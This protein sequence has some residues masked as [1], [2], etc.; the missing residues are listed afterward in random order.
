MDVSG[1]TAVGFISLNKNTCAIGDFITQQLAPGNIS[2][3]ASWGFKI[4]EA[5][6]TR[7]PPLRAITP[8]TY[9]KC[10]KL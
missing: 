8:D 10:P 6:V 1:L 7:K 5:A 9:H 3:N 2:W 4:T